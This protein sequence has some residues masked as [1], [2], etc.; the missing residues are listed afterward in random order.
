MITYIRNH[1][2]YTPNTA[3]IP[4][5]SR[6]SVASQL[7]PGRERLRNLDACLTELE[8]AA[9]SGQRVLSATLASRLRGQVPVLTAGLAISESL[10]IVFRE[11]QFVMTNRNREA[12]MPVTSRTPTHDTENVA[13]PL[14]EA[15]ARSLTDRIKAGVQQTFELLFEAHERRAWAVLGYRS[16]EQYVRREFDLSRSRSYELL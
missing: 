12:E 7:R 8:E 2:V 13:P 6:M 9:A 4:R 5:L 14:S 3:S 1:C 16:W 10:E 15:E 11:Q